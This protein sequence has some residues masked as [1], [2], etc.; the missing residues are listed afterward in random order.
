MPLT[1][2][3]PRE[4]H[5]RGRAEYSCSF[6]PATRLLQ[7]TPVRRTLPP[8]ICSSRLVLLLHSLSYAKHCPHEQSS[9][10]IQFKQLF[11]FDGDSSFVC[12]RS[13]PKMIS[14]KKDTNCCS[15]DGVTCDMATGE[16]V[17]LDLSSNPLV[18]LE[19]PVFQALVQNMTKLQVLSLA[20]LEMSTVVPDSLKN[21]S[22]SLTSLSLSD[23]LLQGNFPINIFHLPNLQMIRLSQNPSLVGKF[24]TN[25]WTSPIEYL[26]ISET[27]FSE[28]ADSIGN[29]K[30]LRRLMLG[31]SQFVGPV[32]A[33][34]VLIR[35]NNNSLSG[36]I[37]SWLFSLPLLE[38]VRLSDNQ[39]SGHIDEFPSKSLQNI[40][41]SNNRLHGSILSSIFELVN[42]TDL[43][44]DSNNFSG[45]A[46][47]YMFA[48]LIKLKYLYISHNSL[49]LGTTF[50]IDIPFPK[51]S[52]LSLFACNISAFPSFLRTQDKLFYLDLSESKID[53]QIPKWI[54]KIGKDSL[55]YLNLSHNF[56]TKMKQISWKNLGSLNLN[57]NELEGANPQSL[58]NCTKLEVLD[59][60]NNKINDVFPY[61]L[62]NLPELRVLVL[63]S[64][65]LR[66][67]VRVFEPMESF[68]KLRIL[69]LSINN[70]SGYLPARFFE[71]LN[72]MRNVGADEG[73]LRY[74]GEEYYQ[75]SVVVIGKLHSL[76]LINL[77]HNHFTGKIPSSLGNLAKLESLDLSSN[78]LAGK[79]PKQLASLTSLSVLNLSHNRLDG[80]IP[81]G[82]QF[83]TIQEDSYI[84]LVIG[85]SIGYMVFASGE[86][87]W[88]MKMVVT[89]Q[90]KKS[91]TV[92]P[93]HS[94]VG[95]IS[96]RLAFADS[97]LIG[98]GCDGSRSCSGSSAVQPPPAPSASAPPSPTL[99]YHF[100]IH[101]QS[102]TL[103][104]PPP[105]PG[106][107]RKTKPGPRTCR[108][109]ART[110]HAK[111]GFFLG[112]GFNFLR[113]VRSQ[114]APNP[115]RTRGFAKPTC[116]RHVRFKGLVR[117]WQFVSSGILLK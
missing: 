75:D 26:D 93:R 40:Y 105:L 88:F 82:P 39:L 109:Q 89:W 9:A 65:K 58:V 104:S 92:A 102:I 112:P 77:T 25:N 61:W 14:W 30:L 62:R 20:S 100:V 45:I 50:K 68:H 95:I 57:N 67:S 115:D 90:S 18:S 96:S 59:I 54:S 94:A 81:Q 34:L 23:C 44:L 87:L 7:D 79:I 21:L 2:V 69:D 33:S 19:T 99:H 51:F 24:P 78:N 35:L 48:K 16:L 107:A 10:L 60:G 116:I 4:W 38:Y 64:N 85:L 66:G 70:F 12:Q 52:Y 6:S 36:T 74:L 80:P 41:L 47:P 114:V 111:A 28:L 11:S 42:L 15:W 108:A 63:R 101:H 71:K 13:Y 49:S 3:R 5:I 32:P 43:Q 55:S 27:S 31:Y 53:G 113:P 17:S 97:V 46:E 86:P 56:I 117:H 29:L 1:G 37:P 72:A 73:K 84:G 106:A 91:V 110:G 22:S 76:R 103:P 83:N 8:N 98:C